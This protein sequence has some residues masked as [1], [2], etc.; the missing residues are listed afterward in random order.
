MISTPRFANGNRLLQLLSPADLGL[1]EPHLVAVTMKLRDR[2]ENPNRPI[3][4]VVF[5]NT[6]SLLSSPSRMGPTPKSASSDARG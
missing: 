4:L 3:E 6:G 2:F 5:P 1:L